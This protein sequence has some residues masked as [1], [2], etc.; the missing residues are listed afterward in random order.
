MKRISVFV[1]LSVLAVFA[2]AVIS[3]SGQV[4]SHQQLLAADDPKGGTGSRTGG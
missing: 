4:S 1:L 2:F 3:H